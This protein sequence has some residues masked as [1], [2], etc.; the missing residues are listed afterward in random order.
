MADPLAKRDK[1]VTKEDFVAMV[2]ERLSAVAKDREH[3]RK[4]AQEQARQHGK[5]YDEIM[6]QCVCVCVCAVDIYNCGSPSS[7]L[8]GILQR[9][10]QS[11][12]APADF[13]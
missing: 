11:T 4:R 2:C 1:P 13:L 6:V 7:A 12:V 8:R 3:M 10:S 5:S 9:L